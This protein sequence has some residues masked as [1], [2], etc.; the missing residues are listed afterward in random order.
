MANG[1][2]LEFWQKARSPSGRSNLTNRPANSGTLDPAVEEFTDHG[3]ES[4]SPT[5]PPIP[6]RHHK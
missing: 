5:Q 2:L 1:L 4:N 6:A 3:L